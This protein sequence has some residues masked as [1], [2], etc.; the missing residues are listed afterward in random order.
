MLGKIDCN[1]QWRARGKLS[2]GAGKMSFLCSGR[3]RWGMTAIIIIGSMLTALP[4]SALDVIHGPW[5]SHPSNGEVA[6]NWTTDIPAG[7]MVE[8]RKTGTTEWQQRCDTFAGQIFVDRT[9]HHLLL[10]RLEPGAE[11]EYRIVLLDGESCRE[12]RPTPDRGGTFRVFSPADRTTRVWV[13]ADL[14]N[15]TVHRRAEPRLL[16]LLPLDQCDFAVVLGD[17]FNAVNDLEKEFYQGVMTPF[18]A[19]GAN[20]VPVLLVRGNHEWRGRRSADF[21]RAFGHPATHHCYYMLR[22]GPD[23]FIVL[24]SG[25]D[26]ADK[27]A[28]MRNDSDAYMAAQRR[29]LEQA[30]RSDA[31]KNARYRIVFIHNATY[32]MAEDYAA[33]RVRRLLDG[34]LGGHAPEQRIDLMLAGHEHCYVR[35]LPGQK[36]LSFYRPGKR[37]AAEHWTSGREFRYPVIIQ[38]GPGYGGEDASVSDLTLSDA[39]LELKVFSLSGHL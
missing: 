36:A 35:G 20:H 27:K 37:P 15:T 12:V 6:I 32:A 1:Y 10:D 24:D 8:Y 22:R 13:S 16:H 19:A 5:L 30:V 33:A 9:A 26:K 21:V 4:L 14:Q 23:V 39:G 3:R 29:W 25:E 11:Y 38:D 7:G 18:F 34:L 2:R 17:S 31:C 28:G